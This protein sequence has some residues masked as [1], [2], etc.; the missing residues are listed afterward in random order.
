MKYSLLVDVY[1]KLENTSSRL[2]K[3]DQIASLLS[4]TDEDLLS[5]ITLLVQGK[6]FP[7]WSDQEIGIASQLAMKIIAT[8]TGFSLKEIENKFREIGD[9]GLVVEEFMKKKKQ[10]TLFTR[11]LTVEKVFQNLESLASIEGKGSQD[12]KF[13]LVSELINASGPKE[14]K[15]IIRTTI[16]DLRIG[17]A[18]GVLRDSVAKAFFPD[19]SD[20]EKKEIIKIVEWAWFLR[21]DYGEVAMIAKTKGLTGLKNVKLKTGKP[22]H[23]LLSEKATDLKEAVEKFE[24]VVLEFKFDGARI[25]IHKKGDKIWLYTRRLEDVTKQF[26]DLVEL[27]KK[28]LKADDCVIEGELLG[29]DQK[30]GKPLPF[31][32]LSQRIKRKYD[33]DKAMKDIPIQANL[34]EIVQLD[35]KMLFDLSLTERRKILESVIKE[36]PGKFQ[37]AE[38][39]ITKDLKKAEEF[40][41]RALNANQ[42]GVMVKNLD[43]TYQPGRRVG[44]WLKVKP[45]METLDLAIIGA[46]WGTG[47]R[48]GWLGS[49]IL[50]CR[51]PKTGEFLECGM[52]G[53]GI[54][55]KGEGVTFDQLTE[56]LKPYVISEKGNEIRIKPK[57]IVEIA[58]EEIQKSP[59]YASGFA[60][61]F[62][63]LVKLRE[64]K[65]PLDT[66]STERVIKIY[67]KQR[68]R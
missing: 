7:S 14:A 9:F 39:L 45:I 57:I 49:L 27:V 48:T 10:R 19:V 18:E 59:N 25:S 23:V 13:Q 5:R 8:A 1:E 36:I 4:K 61:R 29:I 38:Q 3:I 20:E 66:D 40:Y 22:Y 62:P 44:Y 16:G 47:K 68:G 35:G 11:P 54:K 2:E 43:A 17:V 37:I 41:K 21:T 42:E 46:T 52:I 60:L 32:S 24:H 53:T 6:V 58:Y 28:G 26:P 56:M 55:E 65:G 51:D 34:F 63:R 31:Q 12:R 50:G 67:S 64:D 33:I 30:T 15:Y